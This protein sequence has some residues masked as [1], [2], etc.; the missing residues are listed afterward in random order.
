MPDAAPVPR[1]SHRQLEA[2]VDQYGAL[3]RRVI[4]RVLGARLPGAHEDIAQQVL[5][6]LWR[7]LDREQ[8][9]EYPAS[10]IY[11][12]AIREAARALRQ[13]MAHT[14]LSLDETA[15]AADVAAS[16]ASNPEDLLAGR[17]E[18][19]RIAGALGSLASDRQRAVRAHLAGFSVA[20]IMEM[21]G[22]PY[23]K[24]R[25]L[26]ARGIADLRERLKPEGARD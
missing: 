6:N 18:A 26:I 5:I 21:N 19:A 25:N 22:W 12:M 9:I 7:Q 24:A 20:E 13:A 14:V 17:A 16:S 3:I 15:G 2:L 23:Q 10:Y 8:T 11:R 1:E 4:A